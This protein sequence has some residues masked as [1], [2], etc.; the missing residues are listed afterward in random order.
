MIAKN[1]REGFYAMYT[2]SK[3]SKTKSEWEEMNIVIKMGAEADDENFKSQKIAMLF[4]VGSNLT[5]VDS[6]VIEEW[7]LRN[8][9]WEDARMMNGG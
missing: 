7:V 8:D 5:A 4:F 3:E 9:A 2:I 1:G 6:F